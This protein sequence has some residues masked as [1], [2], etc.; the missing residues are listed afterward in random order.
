MHCDRD[1]VSPSQTE[2]WKENVRCDFTPRQGH[3]ENP[4]G[5][6]LTR[7]ARPAQID[8]ERDGLAFRCVRCG[9]NS[10]S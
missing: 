6:A 2:I 5:L 4:G 7:R 8:R 1:N 10:R 3:R 9:A